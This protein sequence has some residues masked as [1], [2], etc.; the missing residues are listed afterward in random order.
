MMEQYLVIDVGGT[1][2]KYAVMDKNITFIEKGIK[3]T[4][5]E[6]GV[7][8][9]L[10][11]IFE[12]YRLYDKQVEG[13][14]MSLPGVIDSETG[15]CHTGG[16]LTYNA[17]QPIAKL[18]CEKCNAKVHIEND[19]KCAALAE[20]WKG[21]LKDCQNGLVMILG[22]GI[23]GGIVIDGKLLRGA[24]FFAGE[25]SYLD[26]N[27]DQWED[28]SSCFGLR[29]GAVSMIRRIKEVKGIKDDSF[30]GLSAFELINSGDERALEVFYQFARGIAIQLCNLQVILDMEVV[31][32][33]GGISRQDVVIETIKKCWDEVV[34]RHPSKRTA[35]TLPQ[36]KLVRCEFA[37]D[38]NLVGAL[39][40]YLDF[41]KLSVG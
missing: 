22:T 32:I 13:I 7:D 40:S 38:A 4:P 33:G 19:A 9:F 14:A 27:A 34:D 12:I 41:Y 30:D 1:D 29:N 18:L 23:G 5:Y 11:A 36:A 8:G 24:H 2:I 28:A 37:G 15:Y 25:L 16:N 10:D 21:A 39:Y 20:Y 35:A 17:K 6:H 3:R 31:A 26:I